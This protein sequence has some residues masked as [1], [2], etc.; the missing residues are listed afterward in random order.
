MKE[1]PANVS[2]SVRRRNP[3]LYGTTTV[4]M[5]F[6][7]Q[8]VTV[9]LPPKRIRQNTKPSTT[10]HLVAC[11]QTRHSEPPTHK[12]TL[13]V[14][15]LER[16]ISS[17]LSSRRREQLSLC[18]RTCRVHGVRGSDPGGFSCRDSQW[19][20]RTPKPGPH[21]GSSSWS[22]RLLRP[23]RRASFGKPGP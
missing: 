3:E 11:S 19:A 5:H 13:R 17:S 23:Q 14:R 16:A 8:P 15:R 20:S 2:E 7:G 22:P 18:E 6:H 10:F 4:K 21:D 1:L 9:E 12:L